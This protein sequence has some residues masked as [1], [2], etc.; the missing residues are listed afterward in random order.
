LRLLHQFFG[1]G[2]RFRIRQ[3]WLGIAADQ[4][5]LLALEQMSQLWHMAQ[6]RQNCP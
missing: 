5:L 6:F 3:V 4:T 2:G 1:D